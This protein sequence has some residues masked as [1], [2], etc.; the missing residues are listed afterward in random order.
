MRLFIAIHFPEEIKSA[1]R[2]IRNSLKES[3]LCGNFTSDENL[4]LT[5]VFLGEC[6]NY[7]TGIIKSVMNEVLFPAFQLL[8]EK[9]GYFKRDG[10]NTWWVGLKD[11][12]TLSD[13][14]ANLTRRLKQKGFLLENRNY[15]PHVTIGREVKLRSGFVQP[16]V[17]QIGFNVSSIE[18]MTSERINGKMTYRAI[19][20]KQCVPLHSN[21]QT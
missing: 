10:G 16:E 4:H 8:L 21:V 1:L 20:Q 17:Q 11:N 6:D 19:Y 13:L 2:A 3:A 9:A 18:L 14:Q 15:K 12:K 7:Q 5:L